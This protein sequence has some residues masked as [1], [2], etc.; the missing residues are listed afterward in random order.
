MTGWHEV[1]GSSRAIDAAVVR[2]RADLVATPSARM[3]PLG[4]EGPKE[5]APSVRAGLPKNQEPLLGPKDRHP[6]VG[7]IVGKSRDRA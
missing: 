5:I 4:P 7:F 2:A 1:K 3:G 6:V